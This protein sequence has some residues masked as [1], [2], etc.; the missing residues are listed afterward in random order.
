MSQL[1]TR[2]RLCLARLPLAVGG[3]ALSRN[4]VDQISGIAGR[5]FR[6]GQELVIVAE[7]VFARPDEVLAR[8]PGLGD[9]TADNRLKI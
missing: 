8:D 7:L 3:H 1:L 5:S 2:I 6:R 9:G 4:G